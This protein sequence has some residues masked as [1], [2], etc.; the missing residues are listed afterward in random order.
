MS[1][2]NDLVIVFHSAF[3]YYAGRIQPIR[4]TLQ[5]RLKR[6]P[7]DDETIEYIVG[8]RR[9]NE[10][11]CLISDEKLST[12]LIAAL[13]ST[14]AFTSGER[15][16]LAA[17][18]EA[19]ENFSYE[20]AELDVS[21]FREKYFV[22]LAEG[23]RRRSESR[24]HAG[25]RHDERAFFNDRRAT[26][27]YNDWCRR[28]PWTPEEAT[29]LSLGKSPEF[30][31][32]AKLQEYTCL[33]GS[34]FRDEFK[35]RLDL[36]ERGTNAIALTPI[37]FLA[38][39][40]RNAM[41]LPLEFKEACSSAKGRKAALRMSIEGNTNRLH[42]TYSVILGFMVKHYGLKLK[43]DV[44]DDEKKARKLALKTALR[45]LENTGARID[46]Q[47][48]ADIVED[49][50]TWAREHGQPIYETDSSSTSANAKSGGRLPQSR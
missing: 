26:A 9:N 7:Y 25:R 40:E 3:P 49:A 47:T 37:S 15:Q 21:S 36:I 8:A 12:N 19:A 44:S 27:D 39:A 33:H 16:E 34:P 4:K 6:V 28:V 18:I 43:P 48:L 30:V 14:K 13:T 50:V 22:E 17:Y 41:T 10:D 31:N 23:D 2:R 46:K 45:D 42:R 35:S 32:L 5:K 1:H 24:L 38:W 20:L 11:E 29:A